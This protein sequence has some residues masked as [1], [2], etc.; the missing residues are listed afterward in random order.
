MPPDEPRIG[1][2]RR[3]RRDSTP[4]ESL[5][6]RAIRNRQLDGFKF[7]RQ[8]PIDRYFADF[9]CD[10]ARVV[11]DL[12]GGQHAEAEAYDDAR[13]EVLEQAGYRVLRFWNH[14]VTGELD[15]VLS[16]ISAVL[17]LAKP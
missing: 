13:T 9:A 11:V 15:N 10:E 17:D 4:A 2:A 3:L 1:R 12:D 5:L 8:A 16:E 6:W 14:N 7:R